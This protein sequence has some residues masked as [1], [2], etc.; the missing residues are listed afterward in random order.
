MICPT[1]GPMQMISDRAPPRDDAYRTLLVMLPGATDAA[2][3]FLRHGFVRALRERRLPVDAMLVDAHTDYYLDRS[4]ASRLAQDVVVPARTR[5]YRQ[6]WLLGISLGGMGALLCARAH[7]GEIDGV[8]LLAP[9]LGN[10]GRIA[11]IA[12]RGGLDDWQ[13]DTIEPQNDEQTLLAWLKSYRFDDPAAPAIYLG[14]GLADRFAPAS[15][16][17]AQR[18]PAERVA[19][20]PGGHDWAT[21]RHLWDHFLDHDLM[22]STSVDGPQ[23]QTA[24]NR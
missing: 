22:H 1:G 12:R 24:A 10:R 8:I 15:A 13:P 14:Y 18:L 11:E 7:P 2:E 16:M 21:W 23:A 19:A 9:Y 20:K 17:L 6:I 5:Q 3:D 4:I